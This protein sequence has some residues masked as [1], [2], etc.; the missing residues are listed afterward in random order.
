MKRG[1]CLS[2]KKFR[3]GQNF[4]TV[5]NTSE[6]LA[7]L[8]LHRYDDVSSRRIASGAAQINT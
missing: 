3:A 1:G 7:L 4:H 6:A 8:A 2:T 5:P